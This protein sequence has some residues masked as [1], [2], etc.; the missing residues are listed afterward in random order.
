MN[1]QSLPPGSTAQK[2]SLTSSPQLLELWKGNPFPNISNSDYDSI[3]WA[4]SYNKVQKLRQSI[5]VA[6]QKISLCSDAERPMAIRHLQNLQK[7]MV[8][9]YDNLCVS[10]RRVTQINKGRNSP[11]LDTF[12]VQ[13]K[14][15]RYRLILVIR[16]Y[17]NIANWEP[18]PVKRTYIPKKDGKLRPLG[19]PTIMD[20][21]VQAI[22]KNALEPEWE[23]NA[24]LGSYGFRPGRSTWDAIER[25]HDTLTTKNNSLPKKQWILDADIKGCFDNI[26]HEYLL[27][28]I[29]GFPFKPLVKRWLEAGYIDKNV[30]NQ[31]DLGTPQ[32]GIISP[33]LA[34]IALD[35]IEKELGV[36]YRK[37]K[38]DNP[39]G[40]R[41]T[42]DDYKPKRS[43]PATDF[44]LSIPYGPA[45]SIGPLP[46]NTEIMH[47]ISF[48]RY[49]DDFV[50]LCETKDD[51]IAAKSKLQH[52]LRARGLEIAENKT[53]IRHVTDG[54]DFLGCS[55]RSFKSNIN[56]KG[57][58][59]MKTEGYKLIIRPSQTSTKKFREKLKLI[60]DSYRGTST[61]RL[62]SK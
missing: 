4:K 55:I 42:I 58:R 59:G 46:P 15:E 29:A 28:K 3:D 17:V 54:F 35:G 44:L 22:V 57:N 53:N 56:I 31:T 40:F 20:R 51:A 27:S 49:A 52:I 43:N 26:S 12:I 45:I 39:L 37:R 36:K 61:D 1:S 8:Y 18:T 38:A 13:T 10:V 50:V 62:I 30:F 19:I 21:I 16:N 2:R 34:N 7:R 60:F 33:L 5:F 11:G 9:S 6:T 23:C 41:L 48:V 32:G 47:P 14:E 24:D 25:I